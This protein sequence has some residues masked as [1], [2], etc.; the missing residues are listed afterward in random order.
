[1]VIKRVSLMHKGGSYQYRLHNQKLNK[2]SLDY[3]GLIWYLNK[4]FEK[5]PDDYFLKGPRSS[6]LKFKL[7]N[8]NIHQIIGHEV[9][10]L[11]EMGLK[12]NGERYHTNHSKVQVF[13]LENDDK[14]V[15]VEVPIWIKKDEL[16]NFNGIFDSDEPLT[17]HID[18]LRI[19][20]GKI[21]VW[22]YKPKAFDEKYAA[23]QVFFYS[24]MLSKRSGIPLS[25][26]RCGYFDER[27]AFIFKPELKNLIKESLL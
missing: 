14:T 27:Y 8:L 18:I 21:W 1:M 2:L 7:N 16:N 6:S 19:E 22:D 26:F 23:T 20:D 25:R 11:C 4:V 12:I 5:C 13:M 17:G 3:P 10:N 15:S 9:N 24:L